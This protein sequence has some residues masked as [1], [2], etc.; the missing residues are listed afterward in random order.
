MELVAGKKEVDI[1]NNNA[2]APPS[3]DEDRERVALD[4]KA[5]LHPLK[6]RPLSLLF[7]IICSSVYL[8]L[9]IRLLIPLFIVWKSILYV[10]GF[11]VFKHWRTKLFLSSGYFHIRWMIFWISVEGDEYSC[12]IWILN[13][14]NR[15]KLI[16]CALF[17][18]EEFMEES[19]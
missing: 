9:R 5:G 2:Q 8:F 18:M 19:I 1:S 7:F 4:L 3:S 6:V 15:S 13:S 10:L 16:C 11:I 12:L 17:V 14:L